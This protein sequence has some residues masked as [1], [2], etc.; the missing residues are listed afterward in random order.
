[1]ATSATYW[2]RV[3]VNRLLVA[4]FALRF[5]MLAVETELG[6]SRVIK[7]HCRPCFFCVTVHTLRPQ[8]TPMDIIFRMTPHA[9]QW[10]RPAVHRPRM[11]AFAS[12]GRMLAL[13]REPGVGVIEFNF[14]PF[15]RRMAIGTSRSK[16]A[17]VDVIAGV[18]T[19]AVARNRRRK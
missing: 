17:F 7:T 16:T 14:A 4:C 11:T 2:R 1:M 13:Q 19:N 12:R 8:Q 10:R 9:R 18:T 5:G 6:V 3:C 15:R